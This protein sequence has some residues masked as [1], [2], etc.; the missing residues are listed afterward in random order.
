MLKDNRIR[1]LHDF[2][3]AGECFPGVE[4]KGGVCYFLWD[5]DNRGECL[6]NTHKNNVIMSQAQRPLLEDG[7]NTFIRYNESIS[8][9]RKVK[10]L[11]ED[12]IDTLMSG[13]TPFGL[14][15]N[16]KE[17]VDYKDDNHKILL[18]YRGGRGYISE[19]QISTNIKSIPLHKILVPK[20]WGN[21]SSGKTPDVIKPFYTEPNS[22]CTQTYI[23]AGEFNNLENAMNYKKYL[24]TDFAGFLISL[25]KNTQDAMKGVYSFVPIQDFNEE[26]TD[27]KLYKK[28][29]LTQEE[30]DFIESMIRPME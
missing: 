18:Y 29:G 6:V 8:I 19:K 2:L 21:G 1:V 22:A 13:Q 9:L 28:Y 14:Y 12:T 16:F 23:V 24:E 7:C 5:R 17:F 11:K 20:A 3:D 30:I 15:S 4:I 10:Q 25:R 26:W 27:E